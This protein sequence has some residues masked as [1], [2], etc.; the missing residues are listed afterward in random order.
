MS[1]KTLYFFTNDN[2]IFYFN[3]PLHYFCFFIALI[4]LSV[5]SNKFGPSTILLDLQNREISQLKA[6]Q[7][8]YRL[9]YTS[10]PYV[11]AH[12]VGKLVV[13]QLN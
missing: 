8:M 12:G 5:M 2:F 10:S 3:D 11:L 1:A 6:N 13:V 4:T 9:L 7:N